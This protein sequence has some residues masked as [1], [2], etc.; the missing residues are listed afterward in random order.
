[1]ARD[2]LEP[3]HV[4]CE[5]LA[6]EQ[7]LAV[8]QIENDHSGA[9]TSR[10]LHLALDDPR[11]DLPERAPDPRGVLADARGGGHLLLHEGHGPREP[12][13]SAGRIGRCS[14]RRV[15][16]HAIQT[17]TVTLHPRQLD[18]KGGALRTMLERTWTEPLPILAWLIEHPDG[19]IVVDTGGTAALSK[20]GHLPWW[21]PYYRL[22]VRF[23]VTSDDEIGPRLRAAGVDP[24]NVRTVVLTHLHSDHAAGLSHFPHSEVLVARAEWERARGPRGKALGYLNGDFPPASPPPS[25][26]STPTPTERSRRATSWRR[27]SA[28]SPPRATRPATSPSSSRTSGR[29]FFIAGDVTYS[30]EILRRGAFDGLTDD[31]R[32]SAETVARVKEFVDER[33]AVY[34]PTHDP[35]S[36]SR[37]SA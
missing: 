11:P 16:V 7:R 31:K 36:P 2:V 32:T 5:H 8:S 17:G 19:P 22:A 4:A 15:R 35:E 6:R 13:R 34:L 9:D 29:T 14:V 33:R 1:M 37:A 27:A 10:L 23:H 24:A 25:S 20:P 12:R 21:H 30:E 26:T 3:A 28:L 18:G